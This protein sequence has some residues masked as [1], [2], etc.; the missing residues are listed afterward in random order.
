MQSIGPMGKSVQDI[1][2]LY[3]LIQEQPNHTNNKVK[4]L[5]IIFTPLIVDY[6]LSYATQN[7][8]QVVMDNLESDFSVHED[9]PQYLKEIVILLQEI[10]NFDRGK[11]IREK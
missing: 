7:M 6:P 8:Y 2:L 3:S 9:I 11:S 1:E 10:M 4:N 5:E